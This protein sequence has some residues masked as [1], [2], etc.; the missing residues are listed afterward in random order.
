V[1]AKNSAAKR[2]RQN[3]KLRSRNKAARSRINTEKRRFLEAV[4]QNDK[5]TA[6]SSYKTLAKL[7]DSASNKGLYHRNTAGRKKSR[8]HKKLNALATE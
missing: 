6:E 2:H 1:P 3:E 5:L 8:L 4:E 7:I